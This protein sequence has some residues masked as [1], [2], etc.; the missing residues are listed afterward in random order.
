MFFSG[1]ILNLR[2]YQEA[3]NIKDYTASVV[4]LPVMNEELI[5]RVNPVK[6]SCL[7]SQM[8]DVLK[9]LSSAAAAILYDMII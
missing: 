6:C 9:G 2:E 8:S 5:K 7:P 4:T 3:P 1:S